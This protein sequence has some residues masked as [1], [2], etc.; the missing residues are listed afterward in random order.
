MGAALPEKPP[1]LAVGSCHRYYDM[2]IKA[3]QAAEETRPREAIELYRQQ[4]EGLIAQRG[5][6]NYQAACRHLARM[7]TLY[8]RLGENE[9]WTN[10]IARLREENRSLRALKE[11]LAKAGL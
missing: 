2:P 9:I 5:R 1:A 7:R 10:Y 6:Q 11:E 3:A 4:A 8:E